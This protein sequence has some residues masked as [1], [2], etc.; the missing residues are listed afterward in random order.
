MGPGYG[1]GRGMPAFTDFDLDG[2]GSLTEQ[3]FYQA[4][5]NR[6]AERAQQGYPMRNAG[7]A[8]DFGTIDLNGDDTVDP[9]EFATAQAEH[10]QQMMQAPMAPPAR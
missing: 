8:P 4:R 9:E 2:N 10:R 3:E 1:P 5:A 6:M 7:K